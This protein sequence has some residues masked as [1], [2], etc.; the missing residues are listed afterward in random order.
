MGVLDLLRHRAFCGTNRPLLVT[1]LNPYS[2]LIARKE[3]SLLEQFDEVHADGIV[4]VLFLKW[5]GV[6]R[7]RRISFDM[8]S[9]APQ[10]FDEAVREQRRVY[11]IGAT[12]A[13][14]AAAAARIQEAFPALKIDGYRDGYFENDKERKHVLEAIVS[15]AP[16]DV[17]CGMGTTPQERFLA[18][19][20]A[21]GWNGSGYTCGGF[22]HQS[23]R[24]LH[25]YPVWIDRLHLRWLYRIYREPRLLKRY[26]W[27]Y[28]KFVW[29]FTADY[30]RWRRNAGIRREEER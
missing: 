8:S 27:E 11:L 14:I 7:V 20:R 19:L 1:Y 23:A 28:P 9:F 22:F 29:Y 24:R 12:S 4:L 2:Y 30:M 10:L 18:D 25:Y 13:E 15:S 21:A 17:V 3:V 6:A 16:D 26:G 5:F